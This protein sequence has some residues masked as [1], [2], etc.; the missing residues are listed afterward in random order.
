MAA[1]AQKGRPYQERFRN[2]NRLMDLSRKETLPRRKT[3]Q[4]GSGEEVA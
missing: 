2:I 1:Q 3:P 4:K